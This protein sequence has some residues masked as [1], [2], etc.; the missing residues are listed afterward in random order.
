M[1]TA[2]TWNDPYHCPFCENE[3]ET[4]GAGFVDHLGENPDCEEGFEVWRSHVAGDLPGGW[5]G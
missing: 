1:T 2:T 5:S 3:L 4:P